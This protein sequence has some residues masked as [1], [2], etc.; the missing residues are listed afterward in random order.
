MDE[1][2][3]RGGLQRLG[4]T[5]SGA[6]AAAGAAIV[7]VAVGLGAL[8]KQGVA[9]NSQMEQYTTSFATMLGSTEAAQAKLEELKEY[10]AKTPFEFPGLAQATQTLLAFGIEE[11]KASD[12]LK[13]IGDI[14]QGS[15]EKLNGLSLVFGQVA[16]TGKLMGQD[17][18]QMINQGFNPL[19][20]IADKTGASVGDLKAVMSGDKTSKEFQKLTKDAQAEVKKLGDGASDSAKMLAQIG[21]DGMISADMVT[22]AMEIATSEGGLFYGA[23]DKQSQTFAGRMSTLS[24][25]YTALLGEVTTGLTDQL[26]NTALP[27]ASGYMD[28]LGAAFRSGGMN[29]LV[30]AFGGVI[31]DLTSRGAEYAPKI[32][33]MATQIIVSFA[34]GIKRSAPTIAKGL[35]DALKSGALGM[36]DALPDML[37]TLLTIALEMV[38]GLADAVPDILPALIDTVFDAITTLLTNVPKLLM[39]GVKMAA[40]LVI[41]ITRGVASLIGGIGSMFES[42]F[43]GV[44]IDAQEVQEYV[45]RKTSGY[46]TAY[47]NAK[48]KLDELKGGIDEGVTLTDDNYNKALLLLAE[49]DRM[50]KPS[51]LSAGDLAQY[52]SI[53]AEISAL[54]P[55]LEKYIG[56]NGL[57]K[58]DTDAI[59]LHIQALYDDAMATLLVQKATEA[60]LVAMDAQDAYNKQVMAVREQKEALD[61]LLKSQQALAEFNANYEQFNIFDLS[62]DEAI[63]KATTTLQ[64]FVTAGGTVEDVKTALASLG[65]SENALDL[66]S[67]EDADEVMLAVDAAAKTLS[68]NMPTKIAAV[69]AAIDT[70]TVGGTLP[71]GAEVP[72]LAAVRDQATEA[73]GIVT[74]LDAKI[75]ALYATGEESAPVT[76]TRAMKQ[77]VDTDVADTGTALDTATTTLKQKAEAVRD[78]VESGLAGG[79]EG[80]AW[81]S[82]YGVG[83]VGALGAGLSDPDDVAGSAA[84]AL[85][86]STTGAL[87]NDGDTSAERSHGTAM[88]GA[89][90]SGISNDSRPVTASRAKVQAAIAAGG[91]AASGATSIGRQIANGIASGLQ[92]QQ[93]YLNSVMRQ[94]VQSLLRAAQHAAGIRSPST[95]FRDA[96]GANLALGVG[97]GFDAAFAGVSSGI[98]RNIASSAAAGMQALDAT[99]LGRALRSATAEI[100][101]AVSL[102]SLVGAANVA[103]SGV[104]ARGGQ[105]A[106]QKVQAVNLTQNITF[107]QPM[108]AP[109]EIARRLRAEATFGLGV[110]R[111]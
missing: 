98:A 83:V 63:Q 25:T 31:G 107:E 17:L 26:A 39:I 51:D 108:Q 36:L 105:Q 65:L 64:A 94:L 92:G 43:S 88:A 29:G 89:I 104:D 79:E 84:A 101:T 28:T 81:A 69:Q 12:A 75:Q 46:V 68:E 7:G 4:G 41:G 18:L 34:G 62:D 37:D 33:Q 71:S 20:I 11:G 106:A 15:Q 13:M 97:V 73:Q 19:T 49:L 48:K 52:K 54:W 56:K 47:T 55:G 59:R 77:S 78:S 1:S 32:V 58:E 66:T 44:Q 100:P 86:E 2:G 67:Y 99:L 96:I 10:A 27:I 6:A 80:T 72:A 24:D 35:A 93:A 91:A 111:T 9:Y 21:A 14:S 5:L 3:V 87:T 95:L 23:M 8:A 90:A 45:D 103:A 16:S 76:K 22:K 50:G 109:Y 60:R 40:A 61:A 74:D 57:F 38:S 110:W 82:D 102:T 85:H 70:L 30:R 53:V 42:L